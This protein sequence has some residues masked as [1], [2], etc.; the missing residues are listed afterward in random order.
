MRTVAAFMLSFTATAAA[1]RFLPILL[2]M[3]GGAP[4]LPVRKIAG[5]VKCAS[6][7]F[8]FVSPVCWL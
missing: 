1:D 4:A 3:G 5:L 7:Y 8:V 6:V 2:R